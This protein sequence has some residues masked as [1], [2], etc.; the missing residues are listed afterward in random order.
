MSLKHGIDDGCLDGEFAAESSQCV[1]LSTLAQQQVIALTRRESQVVTFLGQTH[2][3]I[4]L[5]QQDAVLG[6]RGKHA[7]RFIHA[8]GHQ[9]I[10]QHTD[11]SLVTAQGKRF[12]TGHI[13]V[14]ID[15]GN[16]SLPCR[17]LITCRAIDLPGK[18][19]VFHDF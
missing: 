2:V 10:N 9:V 3:G 16:E 8:T 17:F 14:G 12:T 13:L 5:A 4:I 7:V 1:N 18:E 6:A 15:A 19:Q 11:V